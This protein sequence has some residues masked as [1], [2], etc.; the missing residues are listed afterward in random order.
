MGKVSAAVLV[1]SMAVAGASVA[2]VAT[3]AQP[4]N[5]AF[6]TASS[7]NTWLQ[8]SLTEMKKI[9]AK[10][11]IKITIFDAAFKGGVQAGQIQDVI[12][13]GKYK[14]LIITS[15]DGAAIIPSLLAAEKAGRAADKVAADKALADAK[16]ATITA[17][18]AANL[19]KATYIAEYNALAKKWNAKNPKAKVAL[20]K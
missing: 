15:L 9:A 2:P 4:I 7:A 20:K 17:T 8:T 3:A 13:S 1:T 6:L 18:A 12:A 10:N 11:N 16:A 19:A 14:A 5:L